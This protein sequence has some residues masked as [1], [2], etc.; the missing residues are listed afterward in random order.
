MRRKDL[1]SAAVRTNLPPANHADR[2]ADPRLSLQAYIQRSRLPAR[3]P[4]L[5]ILPGDEG[6]PRPVYAIDMVTTMLQWEGRPQ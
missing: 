4:P 6:L 1:V 5:F 2:V 3:A